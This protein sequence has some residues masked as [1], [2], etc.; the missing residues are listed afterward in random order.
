MSWEARRTTRHAKPRVSPFTARVRV[1]P[2]CEVPPVTAASPA[3]RVPPPLGRWEPQ[4]TTERG[5]VGL[6]T[7]EDA[8]AAAA[9][10]AEDVAE[11]A[12]VAEAEDAAAA[13]VDA[14]ER[15]TD[16]YDYDGGVE[17]EVEVEVEEVEEKSKMQRG[18]GHSG[19]S[20][21]PCP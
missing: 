9:E 1:S 14:V 10:A 16:N 2:P 12:W 6:E 3:R 7:E 18:W 13:D 19:Q 17:V 11:A 4:E 15:D 20:V 5:A 8:A 21:P